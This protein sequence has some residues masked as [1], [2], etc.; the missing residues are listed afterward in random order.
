MPRKCL[1]FWI[2][3]AAILVS[4]EDASFKQRWC[5]KGLE[6]TCALGCFLDYLWASQDM[7]RT[8]LLCEAFTTCLWMQSPAETP[9]DPIPALNPWGFQGLWFHT[10]VTH[11]LIRAS[12][13]LVYNTW[14]RDGPTTSARTIQINQDFCMK[15]TDFLYLWLW[16][17]DGT[18][19]RTVAAMWL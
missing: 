12:L 9:I 15:K 19:S 5:S 11:L 17:Y 3:R 7:R 13:S 8:K 18:K 14:F 16:S 6:G 10:Q 1:G 2:V 4:R